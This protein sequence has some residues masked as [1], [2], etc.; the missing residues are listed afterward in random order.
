MAA[1]ARAT[2]RVGLALLLAVVGVGAQDYDFFFLVL[3]WPGSYCD[4]KQS[5]C[6]PR[7]G[8]P[9]ADFGIHGLWPNRDDGSYPQN[10]DPDSEF[11]P[12]KNFFPSVYQPISPIKEVNFAAT[13]WGACARIGRRWRARATTASG[14]G[15]TSGRSTG[16]CAAA[17]LGD[18]HGYFE[19]GFRLR[20]RLPVFAALRDGGVSP[21]GGYYTL[22]QIKGAIQRGVG[23]EPFVECNRDESGNSQL[24]QLY[25]CVERRRRA[26]RRLPR[27]P[28]RPPLR[29]SDRVPGV[30]EL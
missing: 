23:A 19:A 11:D 20:S 7:S 8:K 26:L 5:C 18:E 24:Y 6:Y 17:A 30:L 9:A 22:S 16:T 3:Q 29:Q 4:T 14:S 1:A 15:R 28:R 25:F 27:L 13:C 10:C 12:S 2:A 21:D